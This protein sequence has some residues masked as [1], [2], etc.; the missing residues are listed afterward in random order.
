MTTHMTTPTLA[1]ALLAFAAAPLSV[2]QL[3]GAASDLNRASSVPTLTRTGSCPG[4][5]TLHFTKCTPNSKVHVIYGNAGIYTWLGTPCTNTVVNIAPTPTLYP[6]SP[7]TTDNLGSFTLSF[8]APAN[9]CGRTFQ[10]VD[11]ATCTPTNTIV[12]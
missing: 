1:L 11:V 9:R 10:G 7:F 6:G 3:S 8:N 12:L 2:P 5:V 4:Q